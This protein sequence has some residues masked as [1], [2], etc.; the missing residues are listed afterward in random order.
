MRR[1]MP[2][3]KTNITSLAVTAAMVGFVIWMASF[4]ATTESLYA[5]TSA[6][7]ASPTQALAQ[8]ATAGRAHRATS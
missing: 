2:T 3:P 7:T 5:P 4:T 6:A 8:D 1:E